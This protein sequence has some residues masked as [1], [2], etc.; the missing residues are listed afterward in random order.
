MTEYLSRY[1]V[2]FDRGALV[3]A[4]QIRRDR[5][6]S[7]WRVILETSAGRSRYLLSLLELLSFDQ[8]PFPIRLMIY[9][10]ARGLPVPA[11]LATLDGMT[12]TIFTGKPAILVPE[13][14][15][16]APGLPTAAQCACMGAL[17]GRLPNEMQRSGLEPREVLIEDR[18]AMA[19]PGFADR[20]PS[21]ERGLVEQTLADC[22]SG[23]ASCADMPLGVVHGN[24]IRDALRMDEADVEALY[25]FHRAGKDRLL[26]DLAIA[27]VDWCTTPEGGI[28]NSRY[29][30]MIS[31]Y[32]EVREWTTDERAAWPFLLRLGALELWC[33]A[34]PEEPD[35]TSAGTA[36]M[37][38]T[39]IEE[40]CDDLARAH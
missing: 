39:G 35:S 2:M 18:I 23:L 4:V 25:H 20:L 38:I 1:L 30:T 10:N 36:R 28:D 34:L 32:H 29:E 9:L 3:D 22:R 40:F 13:R 8:A 16:L 11:P 27:V 15:N 12:V 31:A 5:A 17:L 33:D 14:G 7:V 6:L 21:E 37:R 26:S 24:P 19:L